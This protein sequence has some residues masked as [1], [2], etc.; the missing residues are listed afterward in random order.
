[1]AGTGKHILK[2]FGWIF[3]ALLLLIVGTGTF[4]WFKAEDYINKNLTRIVDEKSNHLYQLSFSNIELK[5][6]PVSVSV[7]NVSLTP[8][9]AISKKMLKINPGRV[10]YSFTSPELKINNINVPRLWKKHIF[11]AQNILVQKPVLELSGENILQNDS[12]QSFDK[13][14]L[15]MRPLFHKYVKEITV[16]NIDFTDA[17][18]GFYNNVGDSIQIS[19]AKNVSV[20]IKKFRTDSAM[21]FGNSQLINTEDILIRMSHFQN[22]M[23]DS[24]HILN[25]DTLEYSL[26]TSD[27][28]ASGFHLTYS[29]KNTDKNLFDVYVPHM[30]MKSKSVTHFA[31]NDSLKIQYLKFEKPQIKF[32][33][34]E[35]AGH[36]NIEDLNNF[37]LYTLVQN[38]FSKIE[39]DSFNL[40]DA[41]LE[42]YKQPDFGKYQQKF[43]SI[44]VNLTRF[45]LDST[46]S[47]N[48]N[49]LFHADDL[50]MAV[51]G[52]QLRLVDNEHNFEADSL[53]VSTKTNSLKV[54]HIKI[55]PT[56]AG[57][58]NSRTVANIECKALEIENVNLKTLYHTRRLP[59]KRIEVT[60]PVVHLQ[61]NTEIAKRNDQNDAGLLFQLVTAY[62]KGVYS[63]VVIINNGKLNIENLDHNKVL[64]YFETGFDFSLSGFA[65]DSTS[66]KNTDKFFYASDFDLEFSNY[67]M[68]LVDNLH[69][70]NVGHISF[71][72][73]ERKVQI[74]SLHLQP[75]IKNATDSVMQHFNRSELYDIFV[76]RITLWGINLRNAFFHNQLNMS[77]FQIL[78]PK[79]Y[80]ENFGALRQVQG[81]KEFSEFY[82]LIFNYLSDFNIK[83][84]E[85]P[86]GELTWVNHTK[87]GKTTS[88]DNE[89][90]A[91]L[92]NF[93]LNEK[94]LNKKRLLFSDNFDIS[95]KDQTF[96]LSDSV[97]IMKAGEIN[98]STAKKSVQIKNALLYP[99]IT[100]KKY[101]TLSTTF[102]VS[103]PQ[104]EISNFDF[105]KAYYSKELQLNEL[106][107]NSPKF[108]VYSKIG[109]GKSLD[110]NKYKFP[111]PAFI[112]SL[113]LNE[114]RIKNGEVLT[115][116]TEGLEQHARSN[117]KINLTLPGV[118]L[119]NNE[120]NQAHLTTK[121]LVAQISDF[122]TPL[123]EKHE[124]HIAQIDFDRSKKTIDIS[125]LGVNPFTETNSENRFVIY[126]PRLKFTNFD[127]NGALRDNHFNF[128]QIT[129]DNP[130]I[131][132]EINDSIKGD[133]FE[134]ARNFDLYP[135]VESYVD[136]I[137]INRLQMNNV[138][139]KFNWFGKQ[140]ISRKI[141]LDFSDINIGENHRPENLLNSKEFEVSTTNLNT[142]SKNKMYRFSA[143]SL[144]YNSAKH[145]I[146]FKNVAVQPLLSKVEFPRKTGFQT[147]YLTCKTSF[148]EL[149]GVD[150]NLWLKQKILDA[151]KFTVGKTNLSIYRNKRYPF[152][153]N[154][155]QS[156]PQDLIKKIKQPFVFDSVELLPSYIKYSEL[157]D[158]SDQPGFVEFNNLTLR[159]GKISNI[160]SLLQK[161]S[162]F[163]IQAK[164]K[165]FNV[166]DI[167]A[168][169][170]F[171]L[172]DKNYTHTL[173]GSLGKMPMKPLNNMLE[174]SAPVSIES[175][176]LNRFDFNL[177]LNNQK[178]TGELYFGYDNFKVDI[179]NMDINGTKKSK[180]ATFWANKMVLN[181]KNPK[182]NSFD[183]QGIFY[184]RDHERSIINYWWKAILT[185]AKETIGIKTD[186]KDSK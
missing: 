95:V 17:N 99:V 98:L 49:K 54:K 166:G 47:H 183:P 74:D 91:S 60:E 174:K 15:E 148:V 103:I 141:N 130:E 88:F 69:K 115:F 127:I 118:T 142:E 11:H 114:L 131:S 13:M 40:S 179:L 26:K 75:V 16:D 67:Q 164:A 139:L 159:A 155:Q 41:N 51:A 66:I 72:N 125:K 85:I 56:A 9:E 33:Q 113:K 34:K 140:Q 21:I 160:D 78:N 73:F 5:L 172:T 134:I 133:K 92:E 146:L 177:L 24:L 96:Q 169:V 116:E 39:V 81:K 1:M 83:K 35:N 120:K 87:K 121:N 82:Q 97:H 163:K 109:V 105:L 77:T 150:E 7:T 167:S 136:E 76:P 162:H 27:I 180:F 101:K 2:I 80:F 8:N 124:L 137:K 135:Y 108:Q 61:Y 22:L 65:L 147:D 102:Q 58:I 32:Y 149:T 168:T 53:F 89:F 161:N 123:G 38:Q 14:L 4:A 145:N 94:E 138:A 3:L 157:M 10:F 63:E 106:E 132:I 86:N 37:N 55:S 50:E 154:Q 184:P 90:S 186:E 122:K 6:T 104:L 181:S 30:Y 64:G 171:N 46:S 111:L 144:I 107:I 93:R 178:A 117:F 165:L 170:D 57:D 84:I 79:I 143:D 20:H 52:Y 31:I 44:D 36:I 25:I 45:E 175:G 173:K 59:T 12:V 151:D 62:L 158:I 153:H 71:L 126:S 70:I 182:G 48:Q 110:L 68:R 42:I 112:E 152:N 43:N 19:K 129:I 119:K 176:Q 29:F 128:D 28:N 185:G 23:G 156:W 100:S 18:Y